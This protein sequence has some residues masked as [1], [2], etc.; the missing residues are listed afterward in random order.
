MGSGKSHILLG[1]RIIPPRDLLNNWTYVGTYKIQQPFDSPV[2][3]LSKHGE[4]IDLEITD[5]VTGQVKVGMLD[6]SDFVTLCEQ[7][8]DVKRKQSQ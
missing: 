5:D 3:K 4:K 1:G 6:I 8:F 7:N 2:R